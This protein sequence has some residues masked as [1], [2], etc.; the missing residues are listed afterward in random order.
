MANVV[1]ES[2]T[3]LLYEVGPNAFVVNIKEEL[4]REEEEERRRIAIMD[5][6]DDVSSRRFTYVPR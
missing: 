6:D 2:R 4:C 3:K 1:S 5:G